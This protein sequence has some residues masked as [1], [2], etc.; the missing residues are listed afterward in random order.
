MAVV[1]GKGLA[2]LIR[3]NFGL[4]I[5][6]YAM[7][8]LVLA[9]IG[10]TMAEFAGIAA[11]AELFNIDKTVLVVLSALLVWW[12]VVKG[13]A[14]ELRTRSPLAGSGWPQPPEELDVSQYPEAG[15]VEERDGLLVPGHRLHAQTEDAELPGL[16]GCVI[17]Q[18]AAGSPAPVPRRD[19]DGLHLRLL[20]VQDQGHQ[21]GDLP[22]AVGNPDASLA[23]TL[24]VLVELLSGIVSTDGGIVIHLPVTLDHLGPECSARVEIVVF[25]L[26]NEHRGLPACRSPSGVAGLLLPAVDR[27]HPPVT[28]AGIHGRHIRLA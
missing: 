19:H 3:E 22:T 15:L 1:T 4:R 21:A 24:Q 7:F 25:V 10:N 11:S 16:F 27:C 20:V 12:L 2:D 14:Q 18:G 9:N 23:D 17:Q 6:V 8:V 13:L 5:T 28:S 26:A